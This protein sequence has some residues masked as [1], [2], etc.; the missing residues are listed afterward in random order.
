MGTLLRVRVR[1]QAGHELVA[2][3]RK[4]ERGGV[5]S[6]MTMRRALRQM[7]AEAERSAEVQRE[8]LSEAGS[9][10][11]LRPRHEL[12]RKNCV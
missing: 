12:E 1:S 7:S 11:D 4:A 5:E 6:A 8:A 2:G 9:N 3:E 10:E